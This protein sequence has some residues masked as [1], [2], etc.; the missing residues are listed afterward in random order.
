[1]GWEGE[2]GF[3]VE[4]NRSS[5]SPDN[6][7][8]WG[9]EN[10]N[11]AVSKSLEDKQGGHHFYLGSCA[12]GAMC[13]DGPACFPLTWF[14]MSYWDSKF[15]IWQLSTLYDVKNVFKFSYH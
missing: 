11:G 13:R 8:S 5:Y 3:Y 15:E 6:G 2:N 1:M 7:K 9:L 12:G 10:N 14:Q 4:M